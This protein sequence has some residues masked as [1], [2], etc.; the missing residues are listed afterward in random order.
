MDTEQRGGSRAALAADGKDGKDQ[1]VHNAG[2]QQLV[3]RQRCVIDKPDGRPD[4][5]PA[6]PAHA[7]KTGQEQIGERQ[8]AQQQHH[9]QCRRKRNPSPERIVR[10][11][12]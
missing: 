8:H 4:R 3:A 10:R 5:A 1:G 11:A 2:L 6:G 12:V 9:E 7:V